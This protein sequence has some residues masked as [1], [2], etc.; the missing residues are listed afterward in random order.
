MKTLIALT[1]ILF[2]A[3]TQDAAAQTG[4]APF[5]LQSSTG[6][7]CIYMTMGECERARGDSAIVQCITQADARGVT[8]LGKPVGPPSD[9]R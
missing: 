2:P 3:L 8:G 7:K 1:I 6:A 5:C 4:N 9:D